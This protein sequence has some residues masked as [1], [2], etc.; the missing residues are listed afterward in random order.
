MTRWFV[1]M[2]CATPGYGDVCYQC[3]NDDSLV[4]HNDTPREDDES[5]LSVLDERRYW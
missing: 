2:E 5:L 4:R 3:G 1:C